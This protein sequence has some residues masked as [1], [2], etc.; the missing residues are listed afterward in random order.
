M[1]TKSIDYMNNCPGAPVQISSKCYYALR[2]LFEL[3]GRNS[4]GKPL[5]IALIAERQHIPKRFLEVIL[6]ELRQ[7]GFVDSRRGVE[8]GYFLA[9]PPER[10]SIGEV[11]RFVDGDYSPVSCVDSLGKRRDCELDFQCPFFDFWAEVAGKMREVYDNT[12][13]AD[14]VSRWE[15]KLYS[16][17]LHYEI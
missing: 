9:R 10:I 6:N 8:G 3:A 13:L 14:I 4:D 11:V 12:T 15:K 1:Y 16:N 7:A 2:A 17:S 5:K